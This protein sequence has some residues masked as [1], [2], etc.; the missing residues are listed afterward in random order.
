MTKKENFLK[1]LWKE[2]PILVSVLGTCPT[3]AI[4]TKLENALGMG[5][6]VLFVL[7]LSNLI[8]SLIK[9]IVPSEIRIP[10]Y[11]VVIATLVTIV[12]MV[13]K[14]FLPSLHASL[15]IFI[16]LIVVN[17]IIL[18]RAEAFASKNKP[19]DSV[20]DAVGMALGYTLIL[21]CISIIRE[22]LGSG[23][24]TVWGD[25]VLNLNKLITGDEKVVAD[26]FSGFFIMPAGAFLV[27]GLFMGIVNALK[28][29]HS[30]NKELNAAKQSEVA[31]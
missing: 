22:F 14:A 1:G 24:I 30:D 3:L 29:R 20:I 23:Q 17:C 25:L 5:L 27:F 31:K 8:V 28:F 12:D 18:G 6:A 15:G 11:I 10:M 4:T 21:A 26:I 7:V 19:L 2:N 13:M 16:P 9:N